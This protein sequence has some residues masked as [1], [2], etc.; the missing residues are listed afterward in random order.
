MKRFIKI[1]LGAICVIF[2]LLLL[3]PSLFEGKIETIV[4]KEINK[5][6]NAR[7]D[8]SNLSLSFLRN[9]PNISFRLD[10]I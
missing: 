10:S 5:S 1:L 8:Y 2:I 6:V 9:F 4:K 7:V 3:L